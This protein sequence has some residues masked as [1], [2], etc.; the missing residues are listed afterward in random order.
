M[1]TIKLDAEQLEELKGEVKKKQ[2]GSPL[3]VL[4][5]AGFLFYL[6]LVNP[7]FKYADYAQNMNV[8]GW[9][10]IGEIFFHV[11][12]YP[13]LLGDFLRETLSVLP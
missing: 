9:D 11:F 3:G 13:L 1:E 4:W 5:F 7:V 10:F 8:S 12:L 2:G 6:G